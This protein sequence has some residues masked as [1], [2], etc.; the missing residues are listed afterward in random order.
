MRM[1]AYLAGSLL[2]CGV[3]LAAAPAGK[4]SASISLAGEWGF[5]LDP[6]KK[7]LDEKWFAG[8][9]PDKCR[10]PGSTD[11]NG[12]GESTTTRPADLTHLR[13]LHEYAGPAWYQREID[14][15]A[16]WAGRRIVL[17]LERCH[18]E[19]QVWLDDRHV[20]MQDSLCIAHVY[21]LGAAVAPGKHRLTI[22]VDNTVKY[23][24]GDH[25]HSIT[26]ETQTNWN[27]IVGRIELSAG[28]PVWVED[29]QVYPD[30]A[31]KLAWV[32]ATVGNAT[33]KPV[34]GRLVLKAAAADAPEVPEVSAKFTAEGERTVVRA[35]L[36][37]EDA[38]LWDEFS[39][40]LYTLKASLQGSTGGKEFGDEQSVAFGM[41]R[42]WADGRK[43]MLNDRP[44]CVRGTL[45]C[46]IFPLTG[47]PATKVEDWRRILQTAKS[48]GL[49]HLRFHSWCPPEAAFKVADEMGFT[50][51]VESPL[52][53]WDLG[54]DA[55]RDQFIEAEIGRILKTYGNHPSFSFFCIGNELRGEEKTFYDL[56]TLCKQLDP[57]RLY[58]SST[59]WSFIPQNDYNVATVRGLRGPG[60]DHDFRTDD[61]QFNVP[62][63]SHEVGQWA[64]YPNLAEIPK[65]TG[66][67]RARNF[68]KIRDELKAK[69]L[70]DQAADFTRA[71]GKL[72]MLLYKEEIEVLLRTPG[73][74][75]F[76]LLDLHDFPGQGTALVGALDP[77][78]DSKGLITPEEF[79]RFCGPTVPL[80]RMPKRVYTTDETFVATAEVA[81]F[82]PSA[83]ADAQPVWTMGAS[84][85]SLPSANLPTGGLTALGK[86]E[87][88][89]S[90]VKAPAKR[91][92]TVSLKDTT[93]AND[94]DIWVYPPA[95]E[96]PP[97]DVTIVH[98]WDD[99]TIAA[100]AAG[101]KVLLLAPSTILPNSLPGSFTPVFWSPVWFNR[102]AGTMGILCDPKHPALAAFPTEEHT[103]WQWHNI[104]RYSRT[105]VLND[106]P[107]GFRP[108]VQVI[109]NFSRNDRLG[110]LI[111]A[112]V[113]PGR[114]MVCSMDL[115]VKLKERPEA[116]Q[117]LRSILGYMNSD[118]F[119]PAG[120]LE[121]AVLGKLFQAAQMVQ[122]D[123]PGQQNV[124]LNVE[125]AKIQQMPESPEPWKREA[126]RLLMRYRGF[127]WSVKGRTWRD[128]V[129][130]GWH[131]GKNLTITV[132]CPQ[133]FD[134]KVYLHLRDWNNRD[135]A[136]DVLLNGQFIGEVQDYNGPGVWEMISITP[137]D[138]A[139]GKLVFSLRPTRDNAMVTGLVVTK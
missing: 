92:V 86:I 31:H 121:P 2:L 138:S 13:R 77:F 94:W 29:V 62:V 120:Q 1:T 110:N 84:S 105:M 65:Y 103:D 132:E 33:G 32:K 11:E 93:I 119:K 68:E 81:H 97:G 48:Y 43:L 40:T 69:G 44:Y 134:G 52:W 111:E 36:V 116:A 20:G 100:L 15:P 9:L 131:D 7:G 104:L 6:E 25:A 117:L 96:V 74:A 55:P 76:Q 64:V 24:V 98:A 3:T 75:G 83:L 14:V 46:C 35:E 126:D 26:E 45:E 23:K 122:V 87:Q 47:Y 109:D 135:R 71:S 18:W 85:G 56:V 124:M 88:S 61:E 66:V 37:M 101:K 72:S 63:I 67:L 60:T 128:T 80:L 90:D 136:A 39:P 123:G 58:S 21:D 10:L 91:R 78:W 51:H 50:F 118:A 19:T 89:L 5:R 129:D 108:V 137:A 130:A 139:K 12:F 106:L 112:E 53:N 42:I 17:S 79:R 59:A 49:N 114:L 107:A 115:T 38:K 70:L 30:L 41:R 82:G 34:S 8:G 28:E 102:G 113:G 95:G 57:R 99:A 73:H 4:P 127:D 27:G 54:K 125:A 22:R 133:G 16:E